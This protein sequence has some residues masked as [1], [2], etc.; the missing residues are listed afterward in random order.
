MLPDRLHGVVCLRRAPLSPLAVTV[1]LAV[2]V[3]GCLCAT[4]SLA[5]DAPGLFAP[6]QA[7]QDADVAS[8]TTAPAVIR[9]RSMRLAL[10]AQD[11]SQGAAESELA[12][13]EALTITLFP[14]AQLLAVRTQLDVL[15]HDSFNWIGTID[16]SPA[17]LVILSAVKGVVG[18]SV[19]TPGKRYRIR[20]MRDDLY[21]VQE[22][23]E[24]ALPEDA[25]SPA[26]HEETAAS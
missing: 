25:P 4:P 16:S 20:Y 17:G 2:A 24:E 26:P 19:T 14:D 9:Q 7:D 6:L 3:L 8:P 18:G 22:L 12:R 1:C 13:A 10:D 15:S 21:V 11:D 23:A 5:A